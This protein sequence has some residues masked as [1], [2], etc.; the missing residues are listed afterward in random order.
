[1]MRY[2]FYTNN[3]EIIIRTGPTGRLSC[4]VVLGDILHLLFFPNFWSGQWVIALCLMVFLFPGSPLSPIFLD[5]G[6]LGPVC[7]NTPK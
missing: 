7:P 6:T 4:G 1:M 3:L 2:P 5:N